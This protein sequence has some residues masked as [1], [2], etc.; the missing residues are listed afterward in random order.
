MENPPTAYQHLSL[1]GSW[2]EVGVGVQA[3]EIRKKY[4]VSRTG[5]NFMLR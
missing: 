2:G 3:K 1:A 4:T 5:Q